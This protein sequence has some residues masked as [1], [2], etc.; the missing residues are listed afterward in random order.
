M[1]PEDK[2]KVLES[3]MLLKEKKD[4]TIKGQNT[5]DG[6]NQQNCINKNETASPAVKLESV[7][8]TGVIKAKEGCDVA[9]I[10]APNAFPQT[11]VEDEGDKS[12]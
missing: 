8:I 2:K 11:R 9:T 1:S 10:N 3:I 4:R 12:Q 7:F 5:A 6:R